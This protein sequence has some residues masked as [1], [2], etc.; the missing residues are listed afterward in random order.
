MKTLKFFVF[1]AVIGLL[2]SCGAKTQPQQGSEPEAQSISFPSSGSAIDQLPAGKYR[3]AKIRLHDANRS[4]S[5]I[6]HHE[7]ILE[8]TLASPGRTA[9]ADRVK[10]SKCI[11]GDGNKMRKAIIVPQTAVTGSGAPFSDEVTISYMA[12]KDGAN[13]QIQGILPD[14][15]PIGVFNAGFAKLVDPTNNIYGKHLTSTPSYPGDVS[16]QFNDRFAVKREGDSLV[17]FSLNENF[18]VG[19]QDKGSYSILELLFAR[20]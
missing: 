9:Q 11:W 20:E 10:I 14:N 2:G 8:H 19:E 12:D 7:V 15:R 16:R 5:P 3:L 4:P 18:V 13:P 1:S 17:V 6:S